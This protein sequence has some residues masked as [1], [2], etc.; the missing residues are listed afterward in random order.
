MTAP[1]ADDWAGLATDLA[2]AVALPGDDAYEA[3]RR[4]ALARF[5]DVRPQAIAR[6]RTTDD[7]VAAVSF[8]RRYSLATTP[9]SG[10]HDF[11]GRSTT[12]AMVIDLRDM[13]GFSLSGDIATV[14]PGTL[15][16]DLY[17]SLTEHGRAIPGGSCPTVGIGGL[18]LGGGLGWMGRLHG[19]T[20]DRLVQAQ[21]VLPSG[22]VVECDAERD[23]DLLWALK[24][25]GAQH[26][27]VVTT[28]VFETVPAPRWTV[29]EAVWRHRDAA[30][31]IDSWQRWAPD[32]PDPFTASLLLR[33]P[34]DIRQPPEPTVRGAAVGYSATA[35]EEL[36]DGLVRRT[37][38][39]PRSWWRQE[40]SWPDTGFPG[41]DQNGDADVHL[42]A[43][44]EYFRRP[45]PTTAIDE[46]V[47]LLVADRRAGEAREL[48]F[49][50]W[51]GAYSRPAVDATAFP[52]REPRFLLKH[53]A[54]VEP[55]RT[56]SQPPA[57]ST[58]LRRSWESVRP[59][60]TGGVFANFADPEL[61][62][63]E[64]AYLGS[65]FERLAALR[66]ATRS[67]RS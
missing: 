1:S 49:S 58:W 31:V 55:G 28:M 18:T 22:R 50:P 36:F 41:A 27:G 6:C 7:V 39:E 45:L 38:V 8:A 37:G 29:F 56:P 62:Q 2:G 21:V 52:H 67:R 46:L 42:F 26:L 9:R 43:K 11:A 44:S 59:W 17:S 12:T 20:C 64:R 14:G 48:D 15:L 54:E 35:T 16:G 34:A 40:R 61:V 23:A 10:G 24:G 60:G 3:W 30:R 4:P 66:A 63:P 5:H 53:A 65:N 47:R 51:G 57:P 13:N 25:A 19:L 32:A 33:A